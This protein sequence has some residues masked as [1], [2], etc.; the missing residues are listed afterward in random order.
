[1]FSCSCSYVVALHLV[2][3][4][5][6]CTIAKVFSAC[7]PRLGCDD[8]PQQVVD[9]SIHPWLRA[10]S[11][12]SH[13][14]TWQWVNGL[15]EADIRRAYANKRTLPCLTRG[16]DRRQLKIW[17]IWMKEGRQRGKV[18]LVYW[19]ILRVGI[20][21]GGGKKVPGQVVLGR[22]PPSTRDYRFF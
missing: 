12:Y 19:G 7:F 17:Q 16:R 5:S 20:R 10:A 1:M 18:C 22:S 21:T 9:T 8:G 15:N 6:V 11:A 14:Q 13:G 2:W 4:C 3:W